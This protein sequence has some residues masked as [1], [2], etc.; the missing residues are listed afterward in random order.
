MNLVRWFRQWR[1]WVA[2]QEN[3]YNLRL[4]KEVEGIIASDLREFVAKNIVEH[5]RWS[6][7]HHG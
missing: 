7:K 1:A 5:V 2:D 3:Q 4:R 6:D